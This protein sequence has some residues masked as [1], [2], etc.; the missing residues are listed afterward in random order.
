MSGI[1]NVETSIER[2]GAAGYPALLIEH[3]I[4]ARADLSVAEQHAARDHVDLAE[5][6]LGL[7]TAQENDVYR[8]LARAAGVEFV[9]LAGRAPSELAIRLVPERL[10]RRHMVVPLSVDNR[11]LRYATSRPFSDEAERDLGFASGRRTSLVVATRSEI[12]AGLAAAYPKLRDVDV[13]AA[14]LRAEQPVV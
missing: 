10:A 11:M 12:L 9:A 2:V 13:L 1:V 8:L 14:R 3:G 7:G 6:V 4:L 5:A